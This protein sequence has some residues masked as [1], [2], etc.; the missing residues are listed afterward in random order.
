MIINKL[1]VLR[2]DDISA[3]V[4]WLCAWAA[5]IEGQMQS[6]YVNG[7]GLYRHL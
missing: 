4:A 2:Y 6:R 5:E 7:G 1:Y 3:I